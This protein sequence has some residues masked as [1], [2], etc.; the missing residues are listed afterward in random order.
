MSPPLPFMETP[1]SSDPVSQSLL[2]DRLS[3]RVRE[4]EKD[5]VNLK[6]TVES[7]DATQGDHED[8]IEWLESHHE[9]DD[10]RVN[11]EDQYPDLG[12]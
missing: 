5:M 11:E 8:R 3:T 1:V 4:M 6:M 2:Y 9:D 10:S 7:F 12:F